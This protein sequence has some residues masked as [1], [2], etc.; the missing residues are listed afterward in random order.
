MSWINH[1]PPACWSTFWT[2]TFKQQLGCRF[3]I[4]N[5]ISSFCLNFDIWNYIC[6]D[7]S[8]DFWLYLYF[9]NMFYF[10][11]YS[12]TNILHRRSHCTFYETF[13]VTT[14]WKVDC[15]L[16]NVGANNKQIIK[17]LRFANC[18]IIKTS[19]FRPFVEESAGPGTI[20]MPW[21]HHVFKPNG[22]PCQS[23]IYWSWFIVMI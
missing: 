9:L 7:T 22:K 4:M 21:R 13:D 2:S 19:N 11:K 12:C 17:L 16:K 20:F 10:F 23:R 3:D 8:Y 15:I 1:L 6:L 5:S 18:E 14:H